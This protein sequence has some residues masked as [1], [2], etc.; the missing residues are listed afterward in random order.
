MIDLKKIESAI[1]QIGAEK[2]I[3]K[4]KL[5]DIIE[6]AITIAY[7][8]DF[9]SKDS[10]VNVKIDMT[11]G[12]I[13]IG[14]EK[15]VV[16]TVEDP[17]TQVALADLGED[18]GFAI[19]D[20]IEIDVTDEVMSSEGFG[21]IA[22]QAA[23]QVIIQKIQET[24]KEKIYNL[25]RDKE[26]QLVSLRIE[27][28]EKNR[29]IFD[30][31]GNQVVLPKSE[32]N[33]KDRYVPGAR[34]YLYVAKVEAD[35]IMGPRVT[36]TRKDKELVNKLFEMNVPELED[37]TV[38]IVSLTRV[39]GVKTKLVVATEYDEVDPAGSLIGPKGIR[40]RAVVDE[41]FGEKIDII[42]YTPDMRDLAKAALVPGECVKIEIDE[43]SK[44]IMAYVTSEEKP[45]VLG[46]GGVNINLA[47]E[48]LGY[49]IILEVQD[50]VT[51]AFSETL[52]GA[53]S[54]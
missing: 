47:S 5:L 48:L 38:E 43:P 32:Q 54:E 3:S 41:L 35:G 37:G 15:T 52:T 53:Q 36:L 40:V 45:K 51:P 33:S 8:K 19:D 20:I 22:S 13:E 4:E 11:A 39:A 14:I 42:N 29:V 26:G 21:R 6:A 2:K 10:E 30:Y 7:K 46:K 12:T 50:P 16:E 27:L 17:E 23:R 9:G 49:K 44:T 28:V 25:F 34:M 18:S 31:N 24:E 1:S